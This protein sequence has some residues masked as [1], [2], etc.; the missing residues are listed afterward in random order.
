VKIRARLM[1]WSIVLC[2]FSIIS[3]WIQV[4]NAA[5]VK[6]EVPSI[7][8]DYSNWCWDASSKAVLDY[9]G[10]SVSQCQIANWAL[11]R[12]DCCGLNE[13]YNTDHPCNSGNN[14]FAIPSILSNWGVSSTTF[15]IG[16][17]SQA[18]VVDEIDAGRPFMMRWGWHPYPIGGF[19]MLVAYGYQ[20]DGGWIEYMDPVYG[21][22]I[23]SYDWVANGPYHHIWD[24]T[25]Q[26][27]SDP[28]HI[29]GYV[30]E[31][32]TDNPLIAN[33]D[34]YKEDSTL[35]KQWA[36]GDDGIFGLIVKPDNYY[37]IISALGHDY[38][39]DPSSGTFNV[40][41][42]E[43]ENRGTIYL[44]T[45]DTM[46]PSNPTSCSETHGASNNVWQ[47]SVADP[48]FNWS[49][50]SDGSGSGLKGYYWYFGADSNGNP[51]NWTTT[52]GCDP[53]TVSSGIYYLRVKT[54]D[55]A[56]SQSS[57]VT[58][59]T[60]KYDGIAPA[61]GTL[62]ATP[63]NGQ[64]SLSWSGFSDT[65]SGIASYKL[66]YSTG[67]TPTSCS[68]GTTI[69]TGLDT[70]YNHTSRTNG[71]AYY[72]RL[73]ATDNAGNQ[74]TGSTNS[75][76]PSLSC[77]DAFEPN[78]DPNN[79]SFFMAPGMNYG[80]KICSETDVDWFKLNITS[81]GMIS[82]NLKVPSSNDDYDLD[83]YWN[84][85]TNWVVGSTNGPGSDE[86]IELYTND[87][88]TYYVKVSG[89]MLSNGHRSYNTSTPY[90][91]TY[92]FTYYLYI[93][94][95]GN[96]ILKVDGIP[97][98]LPWTGNYPPG[99]SVQLEAVPGTGWG[100][101]SWSGIGSAN[102]VTIAIN[103]NKN[104]TATFNQIDTTPPTGSI[105]INS[106]DAYTKTTFV[107]LTLSASD[108]NGVSEM[109]ISNTNTC[110]SW[111]T[112]APTKPWTLASGDGTKTVY[113]W[114]KDVVGNANS[115]PYSDTIVLD[116]TTPTDGTLSATAGN[117]QVSLTWPGFSDAT[118]GIN[119]YKLVYSPISTPSSCSAGT[120]IYSGP[121]TF[122]NH[123]GL[124]SG[125]TY[126]YL[127]CATDNAN[128]TSTGA[129][130]SAIPTCPT[131][132]APSLISP[133]GSG[134]SITPTLD[135]S[136]VSGA[137]SYD[138]QIC[139]D[140]SCSSVVQSA[141]DLI[142][143]Q[144]TVSQALNQGTQYW[145][146]AR[147]NNACGPGAWPATPLSFT[148]VCPTLGAPSLIGPSGSGVS[149]TPTLDWSDV[150]GA[151]S[152]DVQLCSDS[153]CT[154][155]VRSAN[156]PGTSSQWAVS[157]LLSPGTQYW[158][159]ALANNSC[160]P[161][162]W[163]TTP[164]SF[165]TVYQPVIN[166]ISDDSIV[167]GTP[168]TGPT[169]SLSQGTP[170]VT[171]S[172]VTGPSGM[173]I[174]SSTGVVSWANPTASG[175][176]HTITIQATNTAG[177]DTKSWQLTVTPG[178]GVLSITPSEGL[179]SSGSEGGPFDPS[180]KDYTLANTSG[181]SI[182]WTASQTQGWVTLSA[183]GGS[184]AAGAS[185]TVTVTINST[186]NS[187]AANTYNDTVIFT[188]TTN[189]DGNTSRGVMLTVASCPA[190]AAPTNPSPG[191]K[192]LDISTATDLDWDDSDGA[193]SY[194]VYFGTTYPPEKVGTVSN[195]AYD[196][197]LL[198]K[199]SIYY[200]RI[201]AKN[202]CG[203]TTGDLWQF[204]TAQQPIH[205]IL[206]R[207]GAIWSSETGWTLTTPPYY[208]GSDYARALAVRTDRY[209]ILHKD[210]AIYDSVGNWNVSTP[211]YYPGSNYAV[212]LKVTGD[213]EEI[214][215]HRDGALWSTDS[216]WNLSNPPYYPGSDYA[217]ALEV[218]DDA[219]YAILHKD[220]AV[221]DS[222]T[223][224]VLTTPPYY[225]GTNYAV[226]MRLDAGGY[227]ILH[228]DGAIWS[229]S[230]GWVLDTPP[231]YPGSDYARALELA[232]ANYVI[233]H[234]D[235]AIYDS[236]SGWNVNT[237]PYYPGT[238][239]AV[240]MEVR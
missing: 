17:L 220:G 145:W 200:W 182:N 160:G 171:W 234:K 137:T 76:T 143:S 101:S 1:Q 11:G 84:S 148:T 99:T 140:S 156:V 153:N 142:S 240:D 144:W 227:V 198:N 116:G 94:A 238:N 218:R 133:S 118:S 209:I 164:L 176:P 74:S 186:A 130:A 43:N 107:T 157:P 174:N 7:L 104:V 75:A 217:R 231:Y 225:P 44:S 166:P 12:N 178:P 232:G 66:V 54:E 108:T 127:V 27:T 179:N 154:T 67:T 70:F 206:H 85:P 103:S 173:S 8:Q 193:T 138:V 28:A 29:L 15:L 124:T 16:I 63:G 98:S 189:G 113:A 42:G 235:G 202:D 81:P 82:L 204:T 155:V 170:T 161:G 201:V 226:D 177:S 150:S 228:K 237:P 88:G 152:Y 68:S 172:L 221:Y 184:L 14:I 92:N 169:P 187:L 60:F 78:D 38:K 4:C 115:T 23:A 117:G 215:L 79:L 114:F 158:W 91:L 229:T 71:T 110:S 22:Q 131:L 163:P 236:V 35:Y 95:S 89:G 239:Y 147:A 188:N 216:G 52:A 97:H 90:I 77:T 219:S 32:G 191:D 212:D 136:D 162:A 83:L 40:A 134:V 121:A 185:T 10:N 151:T 222:A 214:I 197:G 194:D 139:S 190:P 167:E 19:H 180:S 6:L 49:G 106:N 50:A 39:R 58:L 135:W 128:N 102:P 47:N 46:P 96:G 62:S 205:I 207:D 51:N 64:V 57:P 31:S 183:A 26:I 132:A 203:D 87:T 123:S 146:R 65:V 41:S 181:V 33:V 86:L 48:A 13:P 100:F 119:S 210:G 129:T 141:S 80:G 53:S 126:Y 72:Y 223:G 175:S 73:C 24:Q 109:C 30:R 56:G 5:N 93:V 165:T 192:A 20:V 55:N 34:I 213:G 111:E 36:T 112:N 195:S 199:D 45:S 122:F 69:H 125:L 120:P 211:P 21:Y 159:R 61:N 3:C 105:S 25:I 149:I 18:G 37:L 59:F 233:L 9:Y 196:P 208:P 168:Y 230:G 2:L 224:W